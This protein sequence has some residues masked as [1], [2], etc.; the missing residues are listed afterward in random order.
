MTALLK[1]AALSSAKV[2]QLSLEGPLK[3]TEFDT[4]T[5]ERKHFDTNIY[6]VESLAEAASLNVL[7]NINGHKWYIPDGLPEDAI[8]INLGGDAG[9]GVFQLSVSTLTRKQ[10]NSPLNSVVVAMYEK[11]AVDTYNN[12]KDVL[13]LIGRDQVRA[14]MSRG[15]F[16]FVFSSTNNKVTAHVS[17]LILPSFLKSTRKGT[18]ENPF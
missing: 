14:L 9:K 5:K 3:S 6:Y 8:S 16:N 15:M 12:I 10:P 18:F 1:Q 2:V 17:L 11:P 4:N 7:N 13:H